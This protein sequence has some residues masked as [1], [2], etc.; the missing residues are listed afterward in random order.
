[1]D[2]EQECE[3]SG[4]LQNGQKWEQLSQHLRA[5]GNHIEYTAGENNV[6]YNTK[7]DA[8]Q[9]L[10]NKLTTMDQLLDELNLAASE[11]EYIIKE[12][13]MK[14]GITVRQELE[15]EGEDWDAGSDKDLGKKLKMF[16]KQIGMPIENTMDE[17]EDAK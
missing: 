1:M 14:E 10:R 17:Q 6:K 4:F 9:Q 3:V 11:Q 12:I 16:K 7:A 8:R 5:I 2:E 15:G 13:M